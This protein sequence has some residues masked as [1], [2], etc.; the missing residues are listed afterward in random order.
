MAPLRSWGVLLRT[1]AARKARLQGRAGTPG[2]AGRPASAHQRAA[3]AAAAPRVPRGQRVQHLDNGLCGA[4]SPG[5]LAQKQA[6]YLRAW[7][8]KVAR[9]AASR[10]GRQQARRPILLLSPS[11]L[12]L[13]N[14]PRPPRD[15]LLATTITFY[16]Q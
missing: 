14:P 6:H 2:P 11:D 12:Q 9:H 3:A 4:T 7:P 8:L 10:R 15:L 1:P 13:P 5:C 16:L